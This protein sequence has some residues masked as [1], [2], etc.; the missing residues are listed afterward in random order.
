ME[1]ATPHF[2]NVTQRLHKLAVE[3]RKIRI[4]VRTQKGIAMEERP[5][6]W[7]ESKIEHQEM[8]QY[9]RALAN[10]VSRI[11]E[12][13]AGIWYDMGWNSSSIDC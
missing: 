11:R 7:M 3:L 1:N 8:D 2:D 5:D 10:E 13:T 4:E 6:V 12:E 9:Y